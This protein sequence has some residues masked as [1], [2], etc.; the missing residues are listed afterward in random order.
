[1]ERIGYQGFAEVDLK[2]DSRDGKYKVLEINPRQARCSYYLAAGG[3]NLIQYLVD[4]LIYNKEKENQMFGRIQ[5]WHTGKL[6]INNGKFWN[7]SKTKF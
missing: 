3:H 6:Q 5:L 1:M 2:Y 4:D 7:I